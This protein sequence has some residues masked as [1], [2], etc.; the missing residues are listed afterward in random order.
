MKKEIPKNYDASKVEDDIYKEWEESGYFNPDKLAG[1]R[2]TKFVISLP[3]PNATGT[4]H[5]GHASMLAFEDIMIRYHRLKGDLTLWLPGTDHAAIATQ[6]KVEKLLAEEGKTRH[7][8]GREKFLKRVEQF[9]AQSQNTIRMQIRK[10]GASC[11]WSRE[12]YTMDKGLTRAVQEV[13]VRMFND[14]LIYRGN[15]IVNWC[16]RCSS[17]L[18]DDEIEY[19]PV[20]GKLYYIKYPIIKEKEKEKQEYITVATVRPETMLGDTAVAV[21]PSDKRY[22]KLVGRKV[23][24]PLMNRIIPIVADKEIDPEFGTGALK[25]TPA[26]SMADY[27]IALRNKLEMIEVINEEGKMTNEAGVY[28]GLTVDEASKRV[29][30]DLKKKRLIEKVEDY[31]HNISVCYRCETPIE[32][33]ISLQWFVDVNKPIIKK[34]KKLLSL[35]KKAIEVVEDGRI[36]IIP[37]R[38]EKVYYHW[39]ENLHDWCISRQIWFGHRIP[40]WYCL[41]CASN[42]LIGSKEGIIVSIEK[43]EKCPVCGSLDLKQ[44]PDTLDTWFSSG[45][46]TF[47]TLGWPE[48][49]NDLKRFHPTSVLETGYDILFFWVARMILMT[50]YVLNDI[51]FEYVYLHGLVRDEQGRKMSKSLGNIIDPVDLI[52]KYG[53]DPVRLSLVIGTAPGSDICLSD[54]KVAGFRNF[55]NKLWNI[56][57]YILMSVKN[58]SIDTKD[59]VPK[60]LADKWIFSKFNRLKKEV[61][62]NL[63]HFNFS[64]V[65]EM[66][67]KFTWQEL[68]DWYLEIAKIE[69]N[70][71]QIL[72]HIL[73]ELLCLW[74][75][76][77][78][79]VTEEIWKNIESNTFLMINQWPEFD[80]KLINQKSEKDFE[81]I[82]KIVTA[83]RNAR[84]ENKIEPAKKIKAIIYGKSKTNLIENQLEVIKGLAR[85]QEV[86]LKKNGP[87]ITQAISAFV[88]DVEIYLPVAGI[89]DFEKEKIRLENE[90]KKISGRIASIEKTLKN[91]DFVLKAPPAV[92]AGQKQ[93]LTELSEQREKLR[94]QLGEIF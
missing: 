91:D 51:P 56:S 82:Q 9:V 26:H 42:E 10:V 23:N 33:L 15:R 72:M 80:K 81:F 37:N 90:I 93:K 5:L 18:A 84:A 14:G 22:K 32:P 41:N 64:A 27:Q 2:K 21:N 63:E 30:E 35:K 86:E 20:K 65:G 57:R 34:G 67:Y 60:T 17:T 45:L 38:F 73:K 54:E 83:I 75:P 50:G 6:T 52:K 66:L 46:W 16:P 4:L 25:V 94:K 78:P 71:D 29:V 62:D 44:D 61:T 12:R 68:A 85:L 92:V 55:V 47:S 43:P 58:P 19:K 89:V 74:H 40:V 1:D 31:E 36:K 79:F 3:P 87:K 8:L 77:T 7:S 59:T 76:Y 48:E 11:D 88:N 13:F 39:L 69:K 49:T 53:A 70:K 24:L 28:A